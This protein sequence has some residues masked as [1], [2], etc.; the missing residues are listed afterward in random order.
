MKLFNKV[1]NPLIKLVRR[2]KVNRIAIL[3]TGALTGVVIAFNLL[4]FGYDK[5]YTN[6]LYAIAIAILI[7][8]GISWWQAIRFAKIDDDKR[9]KQMQDLVDEL[10]GFRDDFRDR[11]NK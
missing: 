11:V 6:V 1:Y 7:A 10:K 3:T 4:I 9:D 2:I 5:S 8:S